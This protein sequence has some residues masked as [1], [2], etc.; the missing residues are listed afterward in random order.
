LPALL[1]GGRAP[2]AVDQDRRD[3]ALGR[4]ERAEG[5]RRARPEQPEARSVPAQQRR[6]LN[7]PERLAPGPDAARKEHQQDPIGAGQ[8]R[9]LGRAGQDDELLAQE[10]VLGD[11]FR[12]AAHQVGRCAKR[13]RA[14][15][16]GAERVR[17]SSMDRPDGGACEIVDAVQ[18]ATEHRL[19]LQGVVAEPTLPASR[20]LRRMKADGTRSQHS[21]TC[22]GTGP[23]R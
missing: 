6:G 21:R 12:I 23:T 20:H 1:A 7:D 16:G 17:Q 13:E 18:N 19:L 3:P 4:T 9:P 10:G 15:R 14:R 22:S 8:A 5:G 11:Q 2:G